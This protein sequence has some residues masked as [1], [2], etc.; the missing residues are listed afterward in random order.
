MAIRLSS[1]AAKPPARRKRK[2]YT[3]TAGRNAVPIRLVQA[4]PYLALDI[5]AAPRLVSL[6]LLAACLAALL[7][8]SLDYT[9]YVYDPVVEGNQRIEAVDV[10][11]ASNLMG[12]HV[13]WAHPVHT[14]QLITRRL[15]GVRAA[16]VACAL[17]ARCTIT[18]QER[19]PLFAWRQGGV[20]AWVD[21]EG[22]LFNA[23]GVIENKPVVEMPPGNLPLPGTRVDQDLVAGVQ[24]L[25]QSLPDL[26]TLNYTTE[27]GLE[28]ADPVGGWPVYL[29]RGPGMAARVAVWKAVSDNL[30]RRGLRPTFIDVRYAQA[31]YYSTQ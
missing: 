1:A 22:V 20:W 26:K 7:Y 21:A 6:A 10:V 31:P 28:F 12:L 14:A 4:G 24:T 13:A 27:R 17:P 19:E 8:F 29:G 11:S 25:A 2:R 23:N 15:P 30:A 18:V 3:K 16:Y 5:F 9:F